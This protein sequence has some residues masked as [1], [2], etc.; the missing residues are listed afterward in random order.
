MKAEGVAITLAA[1]ETATREF[2]CLFEKLTGKSEPTEDK[3][4]KLLFYDPTST[5]NTDSYLQFY[6]GFSKDVTMKI[7]NLAVDL[8]ITD[9]QIEGYD[10][11][12]NGNRTY[13]KVTDPTSIPFTLTIK[14]KGEYFAKPVSLLVFPYIP[15]QDVKSVAYE[16]FTPIALL[17]QGEE[18]TLG[19]NLNFYAGEIGKTYFAM[20]YINQKMYDSHMLF[21]TLTEDGGGVEGIENEGICISYDKN[22]S[23]L[24]ISGEAS[25]VVLTGMNGIALDKTSEAASGSVSLSNLPAGIYVVK[26]VTP[27]GTVKTM[28]IMK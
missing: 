17:T 14:N 5:E 20:P 18:A 13:Y 9:F 2:V 27:D 22:S 28:K 21:F 12:E 1:G 10:T 3:D 26:A 23:R 11:Y 19:I 4:Y 8:A 15:N 16:D 24:M 7:D 6:P 25:S